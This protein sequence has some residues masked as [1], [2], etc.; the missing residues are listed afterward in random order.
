MRGYTG[1]K[2]PRLTI[3]ELRPEDEQ[4][5]IAMASDGSLT[6]IF[7]DCTDCGSWMGNW[8][9][10]ARQLYAVNDPCREYLAYVIER[11]HAAIGSV[12]ST[13]YEDLR[14]VGVTYFIGSACRGGGCAAEALRAFAKYFFET[15]PVDRLI[16][17]PRVENQASC[18]TLEKAGFVLV[19]TRIYQ[20]MY[21]EQAELRNFYELLKDEG[22]RP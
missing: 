17:T 7:G 11:D 3:R 12:G 18:R 20:D 2:T 15:Y 14:Q 21:D 13:W 22:V 10:E 1:I 9:Q 16:A 4:A 19:E 5:F 8:I 6:E